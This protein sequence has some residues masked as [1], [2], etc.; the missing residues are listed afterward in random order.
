MLIDL[1]KPAEKSLAA[2]ISEN[3]EIGEAIFNQLYNRLPYDP[4]PDIDDEDDLFHSTLVESLNREGYEVYRLKS[5][6]FRGYRVFYIVDEDENLIYVLEIVKRRSDTY[7]LNAQHMQTIK[8]LY[9]QYY[10]QKINR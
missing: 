3:R 10:T 4:Y 6:E 1:S 9:I 8:S 7:K 2:I 5:R